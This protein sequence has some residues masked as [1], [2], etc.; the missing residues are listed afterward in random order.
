MVVEVLER[1]CWNIIL[2][3]ADGKMCSIGSLIVFG[4]VIEMGK[5]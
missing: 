3:S 4:I 1:T 5:G 2:L